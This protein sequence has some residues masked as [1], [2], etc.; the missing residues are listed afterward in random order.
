MSPSFI[1]GLV[2]LERERLVDNLVDWASKLE[3]ADLERHK[4]LERAGLPTC[5]SPLEATALLIQGSLPPLACMVSRPR[6]PIDTGEDLLRHYD[7]L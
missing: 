3:S 2:L 6:Q 1:T 4:F 7:A 5:E